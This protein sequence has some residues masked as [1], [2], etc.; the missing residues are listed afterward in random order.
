VAAWLNS[1]GVSA[2]VL[3]YRLKEYGT[4]RPCETCFAVRLVRSE[5]RRWNVDATRIGVLGF[6]A[7][8]HLASSAGTLYDS[9]EGARVRPG[10]GQR[11]P[12][13]PGARLPVITLD[14]PTPAHRR[15]R[16]AGPAPTP[17]LVDQL[18]THLHVTARTPP[19]FLVHGGRSV[20]PPETACCSTPPCPRRRRRDASFAEG[21]HGLTGAATVPSRVPAALRRVAG[22]PRPPDSRAR[23][24][25][26]VGPAACASAATPDGALTRPICTS[27][28]PRTSR[29]AQCS[30]QVA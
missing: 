9:P 22:G 25:H 8:G 21:P 28:V 3:K 18:S 14:G 2:F 11:A 12:G 23:S 16:A 4:P 29:S 6:S 30:A 20:G 10:P 27:G 26:S 15:A 1:L 24:C 19:T 7:G 17:A 5:A 13:L